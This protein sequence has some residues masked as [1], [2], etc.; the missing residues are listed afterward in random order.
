[1]YQNLIFVL[2]LLTILCSFFCSAAIPEHEVLSLPDFPPL[3]SKMY[4]GYINVTST[5]DGKTRQ[6]FYMFIFSEGNASADPVWL[7]TSNGPG[8][9]ADSYNFLETGPTVIRLGG[10]WT[11][12]NYTFVRRVSMLYVDMPPGVGFSCDYQLDGTEWTDELT[13]DLNYIFIKKWY[14]A[15]PEFGANPFYINGISYSGHYTPTLADKI[16]HGDDASMRSRMKGFLLGSPCIGT[17][18]RDGPL[19]DLDWCFTE[20]DDADPTLPIW[21]KAHSYEP[22]DEDLE[23]VPDPQDVGDP[24][25]SGSIE[26]MDV[27]WMVASDGYYCEDEIQVPS[28]DNGKKSGGRMSSTSSVNLL[29]RKG[30][31]SS[32]EEGEGKKENSNKNKNKK[33]KKNKNQPSFYS[34]L[35]KRRQQRSERSAQRHLLKNQKRQEQQQRSAQQ[36]DSSSSSSSSDPASLPQPNPKYSDTNTQLWRLPVAPYEP[37]NGE[38]LADWLRRADVQAALH[39]STCGRVWMDCASPKNFRYPTPGNTTGMKKFYFDFMDNTNWS[40]MIVS[41]TEEVSVNFIQ[42]QKVISSFDR[43]AITDYTPWYFPDPFTG[44]YAQLGGWQVT[45]DRISWASII[46]SGHSAAMTSP[47]QMFQ[48]LES[49]LDFNGRPGIQPV[50]KN[51]SVRTWYGLMN[52]QIKNNNNNQNAPNQNQNDPESFGSGFGRGILTGFCSCLVCFLI[53]YFVWGRRKV[54]N[55]TAASTDY[56]SAPEVGDVPLAEC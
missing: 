23:A 42:T 45:Y 52:D 6:L 38:F 53:Y 20:D 11:R 49:F 31:I 18:F 7:A 44:K 50:L 47:A 16:L 30:I 35:L 32:E 37:C 10:T 41:G 22:Y 36:L 39:A 12:N 56:H 15:Y 33:N 26:G 3:L 9:S 40:M 34:R 55:E 48:L 29:N 13:A 21:F 46:G 54:Q 8:C 14:A 19:A 24:P 1:M 5:I 2:F 43:D 4:S 25:W 27:Y 51:T 17:G 28:S